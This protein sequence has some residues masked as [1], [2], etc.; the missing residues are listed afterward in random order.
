MIA[1]A[2]FT[3][4]TFARGRPAAGEPARAART[5]FRARAVLHGCAALAQRSPHSLARAGSFQL[6]LWW[7]LGPSLPRAAMCA[8]DA[9]PL[10]WDHS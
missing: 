9:Y 8:A 4:L 6:R 7:A 5:R 2:I 3:R 1:E 10:L